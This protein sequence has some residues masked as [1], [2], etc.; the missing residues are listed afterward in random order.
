[1]AAY[2]DAARHLGGSRDWAGITGG[3]SAQVLA[4][5]YRCPRACGQERIELGTCAFGWPHVAIAVW[6]SPLMLICET[7][8]RVSTYVA[9]AHSGLGVRVGMSK[10]GGAATGA[11]DATAWSSGEISCCAILQVP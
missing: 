11:V 2:G 8:V 10:G 9:G 6:C 5:I 3:S 1:M 7:P 4:V